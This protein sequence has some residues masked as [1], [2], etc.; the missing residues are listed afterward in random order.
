MDNK[1]LVCVAPEAKVCGKTIG[2]AKDEL[3]LCVKQTNATCKVEMVYPANNPP[4]IAVPK[5]P[6][7]CNQASLEFALALLLARLG[8]GAAAAK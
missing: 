4:D 2:H 7:G 1:N 5:L 3:C 6:E 8:T